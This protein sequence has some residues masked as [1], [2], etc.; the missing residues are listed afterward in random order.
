MA[1]AK[2][3]YGLKQAAQAWH[4]K[5]K[6]SLSTIGFTI[7]LADPCLYITTFGG[8]RVHLLVHVD[9]VLIVGHAPGVVHVKNEFAKL[10]DMRDLGDANLF[11]G[12]QI[13]RDHAQGTERTL[14]MFYRHTTCKIVCL[15]LQH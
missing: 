13:V 11:L 15:V 4:A 7:A 3:M 9:D 8:K 6:S 1:T 10:F 5:L 2:S 14:K 12:L